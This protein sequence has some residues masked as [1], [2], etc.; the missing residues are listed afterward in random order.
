VVSLLRDEGGTHIGFVKV[1]RD[2]TERKQWEDALQQAH[3]ALEARVA[4]RTAE[5]AAANRALD[6][7]LTERRQAE[8]QVRGLMR[9]L[10]SV[11]EDERRRIARDLHDHL[12]QQVAALSLGVEAVLQSAD[13][14]A[15]LRAAVND[16]RATI[17]KLD[18]DLDFVTWELRPATLDDF[19]L[20]VTLRDFVRE[21]SK[22]FGIAAQFH[23]GALGDVNLPRDAEINLYRIA[24]EALNNTYKHA[25]ATQVDV[26]LER[27]D[28][29]L[30]LVLEDNGHGFAPKAES[31]SGNGG[32]GLV[33]MHE[34]AAFIGGTLEL[35]SGAS[36]TTV[37]VRIPLTRPDAPGT[38][39]V[40]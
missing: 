38:V 33:G 26:I 1:A 2:L 36:G 6:T 24:Q 16:I 13:G 3:A 28:Q 20:V 40:D 9:R 19:G 7:E 15:R 12:G 30:V 37:F 35:E 23:A 34:R 5:L 21:W 10:L 8:A 14:N 18:R 39:D 17:S 32:L 31:A 29:D 27:R 4:D 25:A 11:Q 22:E